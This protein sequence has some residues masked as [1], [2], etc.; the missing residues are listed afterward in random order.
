M[1]T[2]DY[3]V[4]LDAFEG[5]L[6]LLLFLIRKDEVDIAN[7][8]V[9]R[10]TDQY[11]E[12]LKGI[13]RID[14]EVAGEFLVMAAALTEIKSR[15]LSARPAETAPAISDAGGEDPRA[16]LV[17][18]LLAYKQYRD[19][20]GA[21][22]Q[23]AGEWHNRFPAGRAAIDDQ[24]VSASLEQM[25][26]TEIEDLDLVD[27]ASAFA[28]LM[29]TVNFDRLGDH[30]VTYDDTPIEIHAEDILEHLRRVSQESGGHEVEFSRIFAGRTRAEMVGL[31]IALLDL[32]RRQAVAV[33]QDRGDARI[34]VGVPKPG[35][36]ETSPPTDVPPGSVQ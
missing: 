34:Y 20:A 7:I 8:P 6:D 33:R 27:L 3:R 30:K 15:L 11:L 21:L 22:E 28:R 32:V 24:N 23:R 5:P 16:D 13:D 2:D 19:A 18:Q 31:F 9:A 17:R 25:D 36:P 10:I 35:A 12:F 1:L 29:E 14:I 26:D 4:Q